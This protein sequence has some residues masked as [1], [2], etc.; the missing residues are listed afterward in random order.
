MDE[1]EATEECREKIEEARAGWAG[2]G[3]EPLRWNFACSWRRRIDCSAR[4]TAAGLRCSQG[5][6]QKGQLNDE[7]GDLNSARSATAGGSSQMG[8]HRRRYVRPPRPIA[9]I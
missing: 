5:Y 2:L 3:W 7:D 8:G 6:N 1:S 4:T 9:E